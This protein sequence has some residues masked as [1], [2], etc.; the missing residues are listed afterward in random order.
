MHLH[1]FRRERE[2]DSTR[3]DA[4]LER[5]PAGRELGEERGLGRGSGSVYHS[6]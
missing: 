3:P 6:S 2:R 1:A 4:E 5:P